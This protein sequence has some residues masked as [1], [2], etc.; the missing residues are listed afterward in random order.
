MS[1]APSVTLSSETKFCVVCRDDNPLAYRLA[2]EI[3]GWK[4][5]GVRA[6]VGFQMPLCVRDAI[7]NAEHAIFVT[8]SDTASAHISVTPVSSTSVG[9]VAKAIQSPVSF[10]NTLRRHYGRVP[11]S[12]WLQLPM[13]TIA[14][15]P[16]SSAVSAD[17]VL[18]KAVSQIEVFMRNHY[19]RHQAF[20][21]CYVASGE[22]ARREKNMAASV[23]A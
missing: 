1:V 22:S 18:S 10:L 6:R 16:E 2:R 11:Q 23:A 4:I 12:W 14:A 21:A 7:A 17:Y 13:T 20:Q 3:N 9:T 5:P 15:E 19:I 8:T